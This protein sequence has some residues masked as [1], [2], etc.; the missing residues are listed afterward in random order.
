MI[1]LKPKLKVEALEGHR[2]TV[3]GF[4]APSISEI[5]RSLN[6]YHPNAT[7]ALSFG[8]VVHA[9]IHFDLLN[10]LEESSI[11]N[12]VLGCVKAARKFVS[13]LKLKPILLEHPIGS[14]DPLCAGRIDAVFA[15]E[16]DIWLPD[17]KTGQR[18]DEYQIRM[19]GYELCFRATFG[20]KTT[21]RL[22]VYLSTD[23]SYKFEF[24]PDPFHMTVF[25]SCHAIWSWKKLCREREKC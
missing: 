15:K 6:S 21:K 14:L 17:W 2:Y 7:D 1:E 23:G 18:Y 10:D 4:A 22:A 12:E 20:V 16:N 13:T 3:D 9:A 8:K 5:V 11:S 19:A 25:K 24:Y